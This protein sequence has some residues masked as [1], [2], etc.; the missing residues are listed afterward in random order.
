MINRVRN[1]RHQHDGRKHEIGKRHGWSGDGAR[2]TGHY[3]DA[4]AD[5]DPD[6]GGVALELPEIV[7]SSFPDAFC[8]VVQ[9][10]TSPV[11]SLIER[12]KDCPR[13]AVDCLQRIGVRSLF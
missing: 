12:A 1:S 4:R 5:K 3:E 11:I 8:G 2:L 10:K 9:P 6:D 7:S 13:S